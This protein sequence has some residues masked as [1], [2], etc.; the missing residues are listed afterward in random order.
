VIFDNSSI[1]E[2]RWK[3]CLWPTCVAI[4]PRFDIA[5][6]AGYEYNAAAG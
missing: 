4:S 3:D 1:R 5:T 6:K 2:V